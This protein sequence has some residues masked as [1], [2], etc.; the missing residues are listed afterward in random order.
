MSDVDRDGWSAGINNSSK[1]FFTETIL[2][3]SSK[4]WVNVRIPSKL[5]FNET[6]KYILK[7]Q[8][9]KKNYTHKNITTEFGILEKKVSVNDVEIEDYSYSEI[10]GEE[11]GEK[12]RAEEEAPWDSKEIYWIIFIVSGCLLGALILFYISKKLIVKFKKS[13]KLNNLE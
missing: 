12:E 2:L 11:Q 5:N 8:V 3:N 10:L 7:V 4:D 1:F 13:E 9:Y 6:G